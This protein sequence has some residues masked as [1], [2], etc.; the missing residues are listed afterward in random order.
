VIRRLRRR[1]QPDEQGASLIMAIIVMMMLTTLSTALLA[2]TMSVMDFVR[3][4]QDYDAALAVA[5]AGLSDA[6]FKIDQNAPASWKATGTSG[7][8][9]FT[10][11]AVKHSESRYVVSAIGEVG[12][13]RH[14]I[15]ALVTR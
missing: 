8:G 5:D 3:D 1:I 4:G 7:N 12:D 14:G 13:S 15:Q 10:Y 9:T 2:R 11:W 6:L